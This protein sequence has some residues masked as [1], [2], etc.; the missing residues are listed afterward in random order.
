MQRRSSKISFPVTLATVLK[1]VTPCTCSWVQACNVD[2]GKLRPRK[3]ACTSSGTMPL[4]VMLE[5]LKNPVL[6]SYKESWHFRLIAVKNEA[7][8]GCHTVREAAAA[9]H[10]VR[11]RLRFSGSGVS[12]D[13]KFLFLFKWDCQKQ[14]NLF[15]RERK[16]IFHEFNPSFFHHFLSCWFTASSLHPQPSAPCGSQKRPCL[17]L[18]VVSRPRLPY[19]CHGRYIPL[20]P[21]LIAA[22]ACCLHASVP[23]LQYHA[24]FKQKTLP[25]PI[26]PD[27]F[28]PRNSQS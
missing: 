1:A 21:A 13:G 23:S 20:S 26:K 14:N 5:E 28:T 4:K 6:Q 12:T 22:F 9:P 16:F 17:L 8:L 7:A 11:K 2:G 19:S 3:E 24:L 15:P 10:T 25:I 18:A 27:S